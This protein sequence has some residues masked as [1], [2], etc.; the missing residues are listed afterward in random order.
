MSARTAWT[1][2][3]SG[4]PYDPQAVTGWLVVHL[5]DVPQSDPTRPAGR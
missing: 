5:A 2:K 1:E 3:R 4:M